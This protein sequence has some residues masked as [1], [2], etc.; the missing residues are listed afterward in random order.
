MSLRVLTCIA[1]LCAPST[2]WAEYARTPVIPILVAP[3]A[4][5]TKISVIVTPGLRSSKRLAT[6][7]LRQAR[8]AMQE[9]QEIPAA[10]MRAI[11][12]AGD[13][14]AAQRYVRALLADPSGAAP[15]DIAYFAAIAV[16]T[17]RVWTLKSMI[18]ALH[19]L[20]PETEPKERV[21]KYIAVLYPHAWAGNSLAL[22]ALVAF[23]GEGRLFGPLSDATRDRI[24]AQARESGDGRVELRLAMAILEAQRARATPEEAAM[25][26]ARAYL[27]L[28]QG[29][30]HLAV[31]TTAENLLRLI[32]GT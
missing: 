8:A 18:Q 1:A 30:N 22:D 27:T 17:G 32:E 14:L 29:S 25:A 21:R 11:A 4:E 19:R 6:P 3:A 28:A 15:S 26:Q 7:E 2:A 20:D 24:V 9:G 16:G 13:G 12:T 10:Q 5:A 23:N 31:R